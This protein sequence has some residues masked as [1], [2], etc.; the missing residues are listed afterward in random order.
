MSEANRKYATAKHPTIEALVHGLYRYKDRAQAVSRFDNIAKH[1][2]L[3]KEQPESTK[4]NPQVLFWIKGYA[5]SEEETAKG[6]TGHFA[7]MQ[8]VTLENGQFSLSATRVD[9]PIGQHPQ[10]KRLASKHPNWGH[11]VM[12][13]VKKQR[14]YETIE[15]ASAELELLHTEYPEVSIPGPA[16][17]YIIIYEKRE[18]IARPTHKIALEIKPYTDGGFVIGAR[19]NEKQPKPKLPETGE[20]K[21]KTPNA[22]KGYF[23]SLIAVKRKRRNAGRPVTGQKAE[24]PKEG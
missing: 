22:Q 16:K 8:I 12:R 11:P 6:Y 10:K 4:E 3:C 15:E 2:V 24:D 7:L 20:E 19:D 1:F 23:T 13:A 18:G 5:V 21:P 17:L 14:V 9:R